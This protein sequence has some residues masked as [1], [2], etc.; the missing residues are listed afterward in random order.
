MQSNSTFSVIMIKLNR[1]F[2]CLLHWRSAWSLPM[3]TEVNKEL[4]QFPLV[5]L[6][7][8]VNPT[9]RGVRKKQTSNPIFKLNDAT[10]LQGFQSMP[11]VSHILNETRSEED[12]LKLNQWKNA[13][14]RELGGEEQFQEYSESMAQ[15]SAQCHSLIK[16]KIENE[17]DF[18]SAADIG[19]E[20]TKNI[21][22]QFDQIRAAN[23]TDIS[24]CEKTVVHDVL[25]YR[26]KF[27]CLIEVSGLRLIAD[28][29]IPDNANRRRLGIQ[30]CQ[31]SELLQCVAYLG[32]INHSKLVEKPLDGF[33]LVYLYH[34][35]QSPPDAQVVTGKDCNPFWAAWVSK[36]KQYHSQSSENL[37]AFSS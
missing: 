22:K 4:K 16:K 17:I 21:L 31:L 35:N 5:P 24:M 34:D 27:D 3:A 13:K 9:G 12:V 18:E 6:A 25:G 26:G 32:A 33:C 19:D 36:V 10:T 8:R 29:K 20:R 14:I 7:P 37:K 1:I 23:V 11:S 2:P 30:D 15:F 28:W